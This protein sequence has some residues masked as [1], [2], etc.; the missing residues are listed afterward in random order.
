MNIFVQYF[1]NCK[2]LDLSVIT[3]PSVQ[4]KFL[5]ADSVF[6]FNL[7][8]LM[9]NNSNQSKTNIF[10]SPD[11]LPGSFICY[12]L[13]KNFKNITLKGTDRELFNLENEN[14]GSTALTLNKYK[15]KSFL[16]LFSLKLAK[17]LSSGQT[18]RLYF[19]FINSD[20]SIPFTISLKIRANS[21]ELSSQSLR[22]RFL[23]DFF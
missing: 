18:Y 19:N 23:K 8:D 6:N 2:V 20:D 14:F 16:K 4:F 1:I 5:F 17:S 22:S 10:V 21:S 11:L 3:K 12:I 7:K 9:L 15:H 13:I